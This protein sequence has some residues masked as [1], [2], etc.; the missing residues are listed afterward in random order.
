MTS[1]QF[2]SLL[3][4]GKYRE[5]LPLV[6]QERKTHPHDPIFVAIEATCLNALKKHGKARNLLRSAIPKFPDIPQLLFE[7]GQAHLA[8]YESDEAE[9][10]YLRAIDL[11]GEEDNM[12]KSVYMTSLGGAQWDL[13][14][15]ELAIQTWRDACSLDPDNVV[16]HEMV[17]RHLN[18]Y[19][20][21]KAPS[22]VF[23]DLYHFN[24]IHKVRYFHSQGRQRHEFESNQE[25]EHVYAAM[26]KAWNEHIAPQKHRMDAMSP[27]EKT[28]LFSSIEIDFTK[29]VPLSD[30]A[31]EFTPEKLAAFQ[32]REERDPISDELEYSANIILSIPLLSMV[33]F[34]EERID[35]LLDGNEPTPAEDEA[36]TWGGD[37]VD[38]VFEAIEFT[39]GNEEVEAMMDAVA[40]ACERLAPEEAPFAVRSVRELIELSIAAT[41]KRIQTKKKKRKG[42]KR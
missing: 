33:G 17:D 41:E 29:E 18:Q 37:I 38:A 30:T 3:Q 39:G 6:E 21:P 12:L 2:N 1:D 15:R 32:R 7:L 24:E 26:N 42:K 4:Q 36:I 20:E 10:A 11:I 28:E 8:L 13:R 40:I 5:L 19:G 25:F 16:A 9:E 35:E 14:K 22:P 27:A 31:R 34:T 23:D